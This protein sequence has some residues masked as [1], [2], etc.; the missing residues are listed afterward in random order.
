[1]ENQFEQELSRCL[2]ETELIELVEMY[3]EDIKSGRL[4]INEI[5]IKPKLTLIKKVNSPTSKRKG[6]A[7]NLIDKKLKIS[8]VA[9]SYN[10]KVT[11]N[12]IICPFHNDSNPSLSLNDK[13][14][15]FHCFGCNVSGDIIT[16]YQLLSN[17]N[18]NQ[19]K[20]G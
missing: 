3:R 14:N 13:K 5:L 11:K 10:L 9:K 6:L 17:L 8:D 12:L 18:L 7:R 19:L 1:M 15:V 2:F 16:F 20:N 4:N